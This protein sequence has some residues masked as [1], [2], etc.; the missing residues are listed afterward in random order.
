MPDRKAALVSIVVALCFLAHG[1]ANAA[2][3][4]TFVASTG[5]DT[6]PCT[7][8]LPCRS[9][10]TAISQTA[11]SGE[12]IVLD[13]AGY[14][15]AAI[16]KSVSIIAPG[17]IYGGVTA[18]GGDAITING[19]DVS[20]TLR[21][22]TLKGFG[23]GAGIRFNAGAGLNIDRCDISGFTDQGIIIAA[24][25]GGVVHLSD[26]FVHANYI[27]IYVAGA[28]VSNT[29]YTT[30]SRTRIE[31]NNI[32]GIATFGAAQIAI[33]DSVV[34][35][36][37][38]NILGAGLGAGLS[39]SKVRISIARSLISRGVCGLCVE[40]PGDGGS[41]RVVIM[42]STISGNLANGIDVGYGFAATGCTLEAIVTR[43]QV[44]H[45]GGGIVT[46]GG[47]CN[48]QVWLDSVTVFEN[49]DVGG[50][51]VAR[52][53]GKVFTR[54]NSTIADVTAT[55]GGTVVPWPAQ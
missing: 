12:V 31:D 20:V 9:F 55:T 54:Q 24:P 4:R 25:G 50:E 14:G 36:S 39:A 34:T 8:T 41:V 6:N 29:V 28:D 45:N 21:G 38:R 49:G 44:T 47:L 22:L 18:T 40:T 53:N 7:L 43:T 46:D 37:I 2:A 13:S 5:V 23:G 35:G 32:Q 11:S 3:Q 1:G 51:V 42:D 26:S 30:I 33:E 52:N 10:A 48:S 16:T 15:P 19:A 17:G 27:G